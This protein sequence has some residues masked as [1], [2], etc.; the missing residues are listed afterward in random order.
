MSTKKITSF[1]IDTTYDVLPARVVTQ[2]K[3]SIRDHIGAMLAARGNKAVVASGKMAIAL[4]GRQEAT[5]L[6]AG[7]KVPVG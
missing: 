1:L 2:V 7:V 3:T 6:D 4:G 5:L